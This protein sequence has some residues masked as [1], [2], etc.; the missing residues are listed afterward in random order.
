M[1]RK[2]MTYQI[3]SDDIRTVREQY[4]APLD[5]IKKALIDHE[6]DVN[7]TIEYLQVNV[8]EVKCRCGGC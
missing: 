2:M 7:K 3:R 8:P 6:G 5:E 4:K 1:E